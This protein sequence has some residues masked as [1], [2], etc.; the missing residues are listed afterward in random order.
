M[1]FVIDY[2]GSMSGGK[3]RKAR[4]NT[5]KLMDSQL[6]AQDRGTVI[7]FNSRVDILTPH[8]V[9][10][11]DP[12]LKR[13]VDSMTSPNSG[14][15]LWD[16]IGAAL[17]QLDAEQGRL[18]R[19]KWVI[20]LTDGE[21]NRSQA[22]TPTSLSRRIRNGDYM[23]IILAVGVSGGDPQRNMQTVVDGN[24]LHDKN[25]NI[26]ELI[27]IDNSA[28]LE[29]AFQAIASIIGDHVRVEQH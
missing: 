6:D 29:K 27:S 17:D 5:K 7:K 19:E 4:S 26:G 20:V 15:A 21:D 24:R 10:K 11:A 25:S 13:A 22:N 16:G 23:I 28:E 1:A 12:S 3:M 8:L 18:E 9:Y 2:S 14:T